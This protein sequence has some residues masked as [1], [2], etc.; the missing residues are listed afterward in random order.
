MKKI[1]CIL[2]L[3]FPSLLLASAPAP[4]PTNAKY[5][6]IYFDDM[7][8]GPP[9]GHWIMEGPGVV[10]ENMYGMGI[11]SLFYETWLKQWLDMPYEERMSLGN[12]GINEMM[13]KIAR[14]MDPEHARAAMT[15]NGFKGGH[16]VYWLD[17]WLPEDVVIQYQILNVS[18]AGLYINF[19]GASSE[20]DDIWHPKLEERIGVF[21]QY[22]DGDFD[23][24]HVSFGARADG[25]VR[26]TTHLRRNPGDDRLAEGYD[27]MAYTPHDLHTIQITKYKGWIEF[28]VDGKVY[29]SYQDKKALKAGY[30]G[31]R[32]MSTGKAFY[33]NLTIHKIVTP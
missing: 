13:F 33:S 29:M 20:Y 30:F 5:E 3:L 16:T 4:V 6:L 8:H 2:L 23:S 11:E 15:R 9:S 17:Q 21:T 1:V 27:V 28:R 26:G 24:Y 14:V 18:P 32:Q 10:T 12:S 19:F 25:H 31:L 22:T 7:K